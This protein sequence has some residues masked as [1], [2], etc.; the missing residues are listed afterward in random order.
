MANE[1]ARNGPALIPVAP[2]ADLQQ[3]KVVVVQGSDRPIAVFAH[4]GKVSAVDN[5][6]P[7]LGF[8]LHRG[9]VEDGILTC[10]WHNA[11]FDLASGCTFD[12]WA[13]DVPLTDAWKL[14]EDEKT[15]H[16]LFDCIP[17]EW[18]NNG[19]A[20]ISIP[21]GIKALVDVMHSH[22]KGPRPLPWFVDSHQRERFPELFRKKGAYVLKILVSAEN[23]AGKIVLHPSLFCRHV[24]WPRH[25]RIDVPAGCVAGFLAW[26]VRLM[27]SY[28]FFDCFL[29]RNSRPTNLATLPAFSSLIPLPPRKALIV[30]CDTPVAR[31]IADAERPLLTIACRKISAISFP[32]PSLSCCSIVNCVYAV[33]TLAGSVRLMRFRLV[34]E[35]I[36]DSSAI[37][38]AHF[39][40][41]ASVRSM[42]V[43]PTMQRLRIEPDARTIAHRVGFT[44]GQNFRHQVRRHVVVQVRR[45]VAVWQAEHCRGE[46]DIRAAIPAT[47]ARFDDR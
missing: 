16:V 27:R 26:S 37:I 46:P 44:S 17:L 14:G 42:F 13:D 20:T 33:W 3:Q 5:R 8:P 43:V 38:S 25:N 47:V 12:L 39:K 30:C 18:S 19:G 34:A 28:G 35:Y 29:A 23:C 4:E 22:S 6:C 1:L 41:A 45:A 2:L 15:E 11:R 36:P 10:H 21:T 9:T 40:I 31:A 24:E 7:H 32:T